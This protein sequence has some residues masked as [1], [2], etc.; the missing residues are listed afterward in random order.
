MKT[1]IELI[2]EERERQISQKGYT[3]DQDD[4]W[5]E[6]ELLQGAEA[7]IEA[8]KWHGET[9]FKRHDLDG[10][11]WPWD[12]SFKPGNPVDAVLC[13]TKAAAMLAAEIDRLQRIPTLPPMP[14]YNGDER[15]FR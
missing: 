8:S 11:T 4:Q 2:A 7:F 9:D 6:G 15:A 3:L 14:G 13:L 12:S 10:S 5:E 1:G